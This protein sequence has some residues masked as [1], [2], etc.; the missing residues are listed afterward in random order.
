MYPILV[1]PE[2][3]LSWEEFD[4]QQ[5]ANIQWRAEKGR[6]C[7]TP[8]I[9]ISSMPAEYSGRYH[10]FLYNGHSRLSV[11]R[12]FELPLFGLVVENDDEIPF[13]ELTGIVDILKQKRIEYTHTLNNRLKATLSLKIQ[14]HPFINSACSRRY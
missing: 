6:W 4:R 5:D 1:E 13:D 3:I 11:T 7:S 14:P 10:Y 9:I 8:P 12:N 2:R